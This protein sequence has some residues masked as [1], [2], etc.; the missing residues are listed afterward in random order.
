MG[1]KIQLICPTRGHQGLREKMIQTFAES[2]PKHSRILFVMDSDQAEAT[3]FS[4]DLFDV[5]VIPATQQRGIVSPMNLAHLNPNAET[6]ALIGD[7]VEFRD[8]GWEEKILDARVTSL[9][10]FGDENKTLTGKGNHPFWS[11]KI[12]KILGYKAPRNLWHLFVD[13]FYQE[14]GRRLNSLEYVN[15]NIFHNHPALGHRDWE[16]VTQTVN[17][18]EFFEHDRKA[19]REYLAMEMN[20]AVAKIRLLKLEWG[21]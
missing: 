17:S 13:D 20:A 8:K 10:V 3:E 12:T 4:S 11:S 2:N 19:Y 21:D 14:L 7:D 5:Q 6:Y 9:V 1:I 18:H 15:A 16:E